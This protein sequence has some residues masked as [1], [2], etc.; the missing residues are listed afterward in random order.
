M[1]VLFEEVVVLKRDS[2]VS[3]WRVVE[4]SKLCASCQAPLGR[5]S[6][7]TDEVSFCPECLAPVAYEE[8]GGGD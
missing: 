1:R 8:L 4:R 6:S 7:P 5:G 3:E 2:F